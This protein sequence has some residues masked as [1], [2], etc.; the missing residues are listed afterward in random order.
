[1]LFQGAAV[2]VDGDLSSR[3]GVLAVVNRGCLPVTARRLEL[4]ASDVEGARAQLCP[5]GAPLLTQK[6]GAWRVQARLQGA[7]ADGPRLQVRVAGAQGRL[8][9]GGE[10]GALKFA[11]VVD[12]V[13]IV[14]TGPETRFR[15]PRANGRAAAEGGRWS[16]LFG[17]ADGQGRALGEARLR[18]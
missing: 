10:G 18:H 14:D 2:S 6:D 13:G 3:R 7:D 1:A 17:L 16:G 5:D 11:S 9:A 4:G 12:A 8:D 15:P